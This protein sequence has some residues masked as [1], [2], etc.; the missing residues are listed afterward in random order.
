MVMTSFQNLY[1]RTSDY[2]IIIMMMFDKMF[3]ALSTRWTVDA[4]F[5]INI[6]YG[7]IHTSVCRLLYNRIQ[8][9]RV[10]NNIIYYYCAR[11]FSVLLPRRTGSVQ[12]EWVLFYVICSPPLSRSLLRG[13]KTSVVWQ[14]KCL[15]YKKNT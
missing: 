1:A 5:P 10:Y 3:F 4:L 6:Y 14:Y 13:G 8:S 9:E 11:S 12:K 2:I 15:I 7:R